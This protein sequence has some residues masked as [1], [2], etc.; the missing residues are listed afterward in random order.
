MAKQRNTPGNGTATV[1][2]IADSFSVPIDPQ[3]TNLQLWNVLLASLQIVDVVGSLKNDSYP[4]GFSGVVLLLDGHI[5]LQY[6]VESNNGSAA[7]QLDIL[8]CTNGG[9]VLQ[10]RLRTDLLDAFSDLLP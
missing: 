10:Q 2:L 8:I 1:N 6:G 4:H 7:G 3:V 5:A 9:P